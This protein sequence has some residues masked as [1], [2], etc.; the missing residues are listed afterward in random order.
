MIR[1]ERKG[2]ENFDV[3]ENGKLMDERG[4]NNRLFFLLILFLLGDL[5]F[6][7]PILPTG[8]S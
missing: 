8:M 4:R 3:L 7:E 5:T 1:R 6:R 2:N